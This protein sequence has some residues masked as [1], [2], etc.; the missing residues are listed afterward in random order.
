MDINVLQISFGAAAIAALLYAWRSW[1]HTHP[2]SRRRRSHY[3]TDESASR[4]YSAVERLFDKSDYAFLQSTAPFLTRR[5]R[6]ERH[7]ALRLYLRQIRLEFAALS[8]FIRETAAANGAPEM[9]AAAV[10][11]A[12]AF[13]PLFAL[14]S[15]QSYLGWMGPLTV[16]PAPLVRRLQPMRELR[17]AAR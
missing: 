8:R 9:A 5:L 7:E 10:K 15:L 1:V 12:L 13:Y 17:S 2:S 4:A 3:L 14:L 6:A 16:N 11:Q